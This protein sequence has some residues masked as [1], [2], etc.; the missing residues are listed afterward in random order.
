MSTL[1]MLKFRASIFAA[2]VTLAPLSPASHAQDAGMIAQ[3]KVPFAFNT[4]SQ[5][6]APGLYRI[7]TANEH[8]LVIQG[9]SSSHFAMVRAED[10]AQTVKTGKAV[11]HR[12]GDQY[13][14][15]EITVP[16]TSRHL[17]LR[18]SKAEIELRIAQNKNAPAAVELSLL[19][20][21]R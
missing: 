16:G 1:S 8:I 6:F 10:N 12:Y 3:V 20:G 18:P 11:F 13:F 19:Q 4:A 9:A 17:H 5:H 21:S 14:L 7:R 2:V 15:N